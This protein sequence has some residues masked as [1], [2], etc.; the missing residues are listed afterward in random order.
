MNAHPGIDRSGE[1]I[2]V[3]SPD[4]APDVVIVGAGP[5]GLGAAALL[6]QA[7]VSVAVLERGTEPGGIPRHCGHSPFG[8]REFS[9]LLSGRAY[10]ARLSDAA[11]RAGAA[12]R[13]RHSAV[14]IGAGPVLTVATPDGIKKF[15]PK[16]VLLA[17]GIREATRAARLAG[18]VRP[19][20]VM[21][22]GAL[23]DLVYLRG[24]RPFRRPVIVGTELVSMSAILTCRHAGAKPVAVIE[25]GDRPTVR[26]P[27]SWLPRTLG[28]PL[29]FRTTI[30]EIFGQ[31]QVEAVSVRDAEGNLRRIAC[32]GVVF[33]GEFTPEASLARTAGLEVDRGSGGP[34][35]DADGRTSLAHVYAAGNTLRAVETAGWCWAEGRTVARSIL[36]DLRGE[37]ASD[38]NSIR[39]EAGEN[40]KLVVPQRLSPRST[41]GAFQKLQVRL[42]RP[43][44]GMLQVAADGRVLWSRRIA[45]GP[46]RRLGIPLAAL[47]LPDDARTITVSVRET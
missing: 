12:I 21:N 14:A 41:A 2:P 40:V 10:A 46:E 26:A 5:A 27:F 22:T 3:E 37:G 4:A 9:R 16:A 18:G 33:T 7:G 29:H 20:G 39:V 47:R 45:S 19:Q 1:A 24:K 32:D 11:A 30:E 35:V 13:L 34:L 6:A 28:I 38:S 25:R 17:T 8:M 44:S 42:F 31:A 43:V 15:A 36:R 23:Q